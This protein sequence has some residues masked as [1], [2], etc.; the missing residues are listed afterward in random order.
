MNLTTQ[1]G[2]ETEIRLMTS[3]QHSGHEE[4]T[5]QHFTIEWI[6]EFETCARSSDIGVKGFFA[7][8]WIVTSNLAV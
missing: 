5:I 1:C 8:L 4:Q 7:A 2:P 6:I 3:G